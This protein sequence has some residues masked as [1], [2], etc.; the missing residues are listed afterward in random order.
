MSVRFCRQRKSAQALVTDQVD[1]PKD[2]QVRRLVVQHD[3]L[4]LDCTGDNRILLFKV[5]STDIAIQL[6]KTL[7]RGVLVSLSGV[8]PRR[9]GDESPAEDHEADR[10]PEDSHGDEV[11]VW[12]LLVELLHHDRDDDTAD[13]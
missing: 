8:E 11:V 7:H 6:S 9:F 3:V 13:V 4:M 1:T 12:V 10:R 5:I 2:V